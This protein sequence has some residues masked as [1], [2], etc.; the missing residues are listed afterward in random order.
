MTIFEPAFHA[1]FHK[2]SQ[3]H[4]MATAPGLVTLIQGVIDRIRSLAS[5]HC[6]L[7]ASVISQLE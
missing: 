5:N 6:N 1:P 2:R 4:S 3:A 7:C